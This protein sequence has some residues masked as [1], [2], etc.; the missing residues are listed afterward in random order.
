MNTMN[1]KEE[2]HDAMSKAMKLDH[3]LDVDVLFDAVTFI[4][5]RFRDSSSLDE[6]PEYAR[7][8]R[9]EAEKLDSEIIDAVRTFTVSSRRGKEDLAVA[10]SAISELGVRVESIRDRAEESEKTVKTVSRDIML[11]HAA[12]KNVELTVTT[13]KK[14]VMMVNACE[15]L[16]VLAESRE[17][18]QT[19][20]LILS[21]KDLE[22]SF[23]D[24]RHIPRVDELLKHK[25]RIFTDLRLQIMEDF[26][27]RI[28]LTFP[29]SRAESSTGGPRI[30]T[31]KEA[32]E[33]IDFTAAADAVDALGD[34]IRHE[35]INKYCL[36]VI[37]NYK[38]RFAPPQGEFAMLEHYEKRLS[39]LTQALKDF[40][41]KHV[42]LF[43]SQ[44]VV[45]GEL[46]MHFC[47]ETRQHFI[48]ILSSPQS[49]INQPRPPSEGPPQ[50]PQSLA[51]LHPAELM[52]TVLIKSIELEN[53]MQRRFDK[54]RKKL[55]LPEKEH[56]RFQGVI[57][58]CF[59][60]YL[61]LWVQHE[62]SQLM[63]MIGSM[64]S[65]GV[66]ADDLIGTSLRAAVPSEESNNSLKRSVSSS[67][68]SIDTDPPLV[69]V[70]SVNLFARMRSSLQRCRMF[71]TGQPMVDLFAV[72]KRAINVYL[73]SVLRT[74]LPTSKLISTTN[75]EALSITCAIVGSLDYCL[76]NAPQL[77]KNCISFLSK[78]L[79]ISIAKEIQKLAEA[80]EVSE[81][82]VAI[83][84]TGG[85]VR[86]TMQ[87]V[88]HIDWW[89]CES[90]SAVSPHILK[91]RTALDHSF[92]TIAKAL[93]ESH[94]R[95]A[96]EQIA[97]KL[98]NQF[99]ENIYHAKPIS[100]TGAQ[101]LL[102]DL[103]E[104]RAMLLDL[105]QC[106]LPDKQVQQ[107][108]SDI[109]TNG[110]QRLDISLKALS[111][112]SCGDKASLRAM[113]DAL[114]PEISH[115]APG[116]LDKEVDRIYSLRKG[117]TN[118]A[119]MHVVGPVA[120]IL[121]SNTDND[122]VQR[123]PSQRFDSYNAESSDKYT[124]RP[125]K[126]DLKADLSKFGASFIKNKNKF[127]GLNK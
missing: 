124:R 107:T 43:P 96:I 14:V 100:E 103:A 64:R 66:Q 20:A 33:K 101:Q 31:S 76:K 1:V 106:A 92:R 11:L 105:P 115:S 15:Q 88:A 12:K 8:L 65:A 36:I 116:A 125:S 57:T 60:P 79:D 118:S 59:E 17:Y 19:T 62:D 56:L 46:C 29:N 7:S 102:I 53:D 111:S 84:L 114:D 87:T 10:K 23:D 94:Y 2:L 27:L 97:S 24:M 52:V 67:D 3:P 117:P 28:F 68:G 58:S 75:E 104:F 110:L 54:V 85:D 122:L 34:D 38:K 126:P 121:G 90:A 78:D 109:V 123:S 25:E 51:A 47:H 50:S 21:I 98:V 39:W 80:R 91:M 77:H 55:S 4:N 127:F 61:K 82:T 40:T 16:T 108:Y 120:S 119:T 37:E 45:N 30:M 44:W 6:L 89:S 71:T 32:V 99:A 18:A 22:S 48:D 42:A 74:R 26:D 69:Y 81:E 73:D 72:F 49:S 9:S 112:P 113:L 83:C 5:S 95:G 13:L 35:I 93:T 41:D 63:D 70:S 86:S